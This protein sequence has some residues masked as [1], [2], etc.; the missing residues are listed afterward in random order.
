MKFTSP[1]SVVFSV[2]I[3]SKFRPGVVSSRTDKAIYRE[4]LF[5]PP[6]PNQNPR[7]HGFASHNSRHMTSLKLVSCPGSRVDKI[8]GTK[9]RAMPYLL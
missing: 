4:T 8:V 5:Q 3:K 7:N 6:T 9:D 2:I 1:E